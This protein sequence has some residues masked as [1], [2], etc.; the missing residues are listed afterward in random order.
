MSFIRIWWLTSY[1]KEFAMSN[2]PPQWFMD[3][4]DPNED[5]TEP[6][7]DEA[8]IA[9]EQPTSFDKS[10]DFLNAKESDHWPMFNYLTGF[11]E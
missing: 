7:E 3:D 5:D 4:Y 1:R 9:K 8:Q 10:M 6:I 2:Y 11:R